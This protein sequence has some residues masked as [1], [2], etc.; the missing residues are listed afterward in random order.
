VAGEPTDP[1]GDWGGEDFTD[2]PVAEY[3]SPPIRQP[4]DPSRARER[5]RGWVT[6]ALLAVLGIQILGAFLALILGASADDVRSL[7]EVTLPP[8]VALAGT[9]LG[10]Y[11]A[12]R[13]R[14]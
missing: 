14:L 12:E 2:E 3:V 1:P 6:T 8:V 7:L 13:D 4:Y 10:F 5:V 9:A 11:F